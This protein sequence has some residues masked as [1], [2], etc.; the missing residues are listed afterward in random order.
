M[1]LLFSALDIYFVYMMWGF[2]SVT[3]PPLDA[4][5]AED[6]IMLYF[7][8]NVYDVKYNLTDET[9]TFT[10]TPLQ[11]PQI[12]NAIFVGILNKGRQCFIVGKFV[13]VLGLSLYILDGI[14]IMYNTDNF[15]EIQLV[16]VPLT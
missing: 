11:L 15:Y 5:A 7:V 4:M 6:G 16:Y 10:E 12:P 13:A 8:G 9:L 14:I 3:C 1:I 2:I